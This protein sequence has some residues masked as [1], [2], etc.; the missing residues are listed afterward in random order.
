M[1]VA[2]ADII[3]ITSSYYE[4]TTSMTRQEVV[5]LYTLK[6]RYWAD[7]TRITVIIMP[8]DPMHEKF[9]KEVLGMTPERYLKVTDYYLNSGNAH[10]FKQAKS[11][12]E[13]LRRV[14]MIDGAIGYVDSKS[15][16]I[17]NNGY[18]HVIKITN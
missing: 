10:Y 11:Q 6:T 12:D 13:M 9:C 2:S 3:P 8:D 17:N 16:A 14:G 5:W 18:V 4:K 1:S 7:G 15:V